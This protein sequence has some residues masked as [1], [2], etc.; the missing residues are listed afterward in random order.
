MQHQAERPKRKWLTRLT[1]GGVVFLL[2]SLTVLTS[3]TNVVI[4][5]SQEADETRAAIMQ[6]LVDNTGYLRDG[7]MQRNVSAA[8]AYLALQTDYQQSE[9]LAAIHIGKEEYA[10]AIPFIQKCIELTPQTDTALRAQL[11]TKL[12]GL[13]YLTQ[14]L[15]GA[16]RAL[17]EA[18]AADGSM[19][20]TRLLLARA[21]IEMGNTPAAIDHLEMYL[22]RQPDEVL[23]MTLGDLYAQQGELKLAEEVFAKAAQ[24]QDGLGKARYSLGHTR[25]QLGDY[26]AA[27]ADFSA[28][29]D[30]G[31]DVGMSLYYRGVI[32][33]QTANYHLA[34]TD[35]SAAIEQVENPDGLRLAFNRG[36]SR[37]A[38]ENYTGAMEDFSVSLEAG[39]AVADSLLNRGI[40]A[41][42]L[43][44]NNQAA[45]DFT[46]GM[47]TGADAMRAASLRSTA[48]LRLAD[49]SGALEDFI[50]LESAGQM[51][52]QNVFNRGIALMQ[53]G[54]HQQAIADFS[55][56]IEE[57]VQPEQA[58]YYR[59]ACYQALGNM[60]S[61]LA[62][63]SKAVE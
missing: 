27:E 35:F 50:V 52:V 7:W 55:R 62:D 41:L 30:A 21:Y 24:A 17:E 49:Y 1:A 5:P 44:L 10:S 57:N 43:G 45:D 46:A 34:E 29:V 53:T 26:Q 14:N 40:C 51:T 37:L 6:Y 12:G 23:Q 47:E 28:C 32:R 18:L 16:A 11:Y 25:M 38:Q 9:A 13:L 20:D 22:K 60:E 63:L 42:E 15:T 48:R 2:L 54:S 61:A 33:L 59:A 4:R 19:G 36:V 39:E 8:A 3:V 56:C 58:L 31:V